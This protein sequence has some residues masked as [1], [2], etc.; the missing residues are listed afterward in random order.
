[1]A[2]RLEELLS[3]PCLTDEQPATRWDRPA[4]DVRQFRRH[5][6]G[7]YITVEQDIVDMVPEW[8]L[9]PMRVQD[10]YRSES[11]VSASWLDA[12]DI[13]LHR[14]QEIQQSVNGILQRHSQQCAHGSACPSATLLRQFYDLYRA[15]NRRLDDAV[16]RRSMRCAAHIH[17]PSTD[18]DAAM[19]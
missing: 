10:Y 8:F 16:R 18:D 2:Q 6:R 15:E 4:Y 5:P 1:M 7:Y 11:G 13:G 19:A 14:R 17:Y 3:A 12:R 9:H